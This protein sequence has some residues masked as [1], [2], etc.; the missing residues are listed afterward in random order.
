[1]CFAVRGPH[2][3]GDHLLTLKMNTELGMLAKSACSAHSSSI[4]FSRAGNAANVE[5]R[6]VTAG[7][8]LP[9]RDM[10]EFM[11]G[12]SKGLARSVVTS[13]HPAPA[14]LMPDITDTLQRAAVHDVR[15]AQGTRERVRDADTD[16]DRD[17][18][19]ERSGAENLKAFPVLDGEWTG[20]TLVEFRTSC[21]STWR[22]SG[23][24]FVC[25]CVCVHG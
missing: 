15:A 6:R 9:L 3:H 10:A 4:T 13:L 19:F 12:L 23:V 2:T 18:F 22:Q 7:D 5:T 20:T 8:G 1:M 24:L 25:V 17:D 16:A 14:T 11:S 21:L